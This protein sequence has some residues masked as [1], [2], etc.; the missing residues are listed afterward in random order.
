M[1]DSDISKLEQRI[2][3]LI[4]LTEQLSNEN[5]LM[6]ERQDIL[7]EE[8]ARLIEK[9]ELARSRVESMLVRLK[10]MEAEA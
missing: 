5:N 4:A 7:V 1:S 10:A 3:E 6:R 9:A 8:R 2:D